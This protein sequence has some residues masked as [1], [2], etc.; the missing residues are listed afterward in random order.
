MAQITLQS[1]P[2]ID[3]VNGY[4]RENVTK[5]I[6][7]RLANEEEYK[8]DSSVSTTTLED[9]RDLFQTE[10]NRLGALWRQQLA[11]LDKEYKKRLPEKL[12]EHLEQWKKGT[13][14]SAEFK[15]FINT[16]YNMQI[17]H[18]VAQL[19][20]SELKAREKF[21]KKLN[22][23]LPVVKNINTLESYKKE[24]RS[25]EQL[26]EIQVRIDELQAEENRKKEIA[27]AE[28]KIAEAKT[29]E[30]KLKAQQELDS[31]LNQGSAAVGTVSKA[32][33]I[34]KGALYIGIGIAVVIT[35]VLI[36]RGIRK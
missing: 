10:A 4:I 32:T 21:Q 14:G 5:N 36:Y 27:D 35:G 22:A 34:P 20:N 3:V 8:L 31:L 26:N 7:D 2:S 24:A 15:Q 12:K 33:G 19:M 6:N 13:L 9:Q 29:A 17:N 11:A 16:V 28:K 23:S 1:H 18:A 30:E 25:P